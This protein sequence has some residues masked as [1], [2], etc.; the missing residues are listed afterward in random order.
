[1]KV[2]SESLVHVIRS[3]RLLAQ[4]YKNSDWVG[5]K[6]LDKTLCG[7]LDEAFED[8]GKNNHSLIIELEK[9]LALYGDIVASLPEAIADQW[10][11]IKT[12]RH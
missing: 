8:A 6:A 9:I 11:N 7:Y 10:F 2:I 1:M 5:L 12:I 3:R 4:A